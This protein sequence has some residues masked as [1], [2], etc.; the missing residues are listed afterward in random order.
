M[1]PKRQGVKQLGS[2]MPMAIPE[3]KLVG[4]APLYHIYSRLDVLFLFTAKKLY[5]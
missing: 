2:R 3:P 5:S 1:L 4:A